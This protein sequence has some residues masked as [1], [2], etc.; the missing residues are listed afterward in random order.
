MSTSEV[1]PGDVMPWGEYTVRGRQGC[2][3]KAIA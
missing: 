3:S 1:E 2:G